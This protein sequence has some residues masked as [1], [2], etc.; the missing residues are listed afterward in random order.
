MGAQIIRL[1]RPI[2]REDYRTVEG[3]S[4]REASGLNKHTKSKW[5]FVSLW[6]EKPLAGVEKRK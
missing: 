4:V 6:C 1:P 3:C 2:P 5:L